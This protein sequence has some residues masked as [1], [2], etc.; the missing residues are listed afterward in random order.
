MAYN[1]QCTIMACTTHSRYNLILKCK[2][3]VENS[4]ALSF[5]PQNISTALC[6]STSDETQIHTRYL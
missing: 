2:H 3:T 6:I 1:P 4:Y 5:L